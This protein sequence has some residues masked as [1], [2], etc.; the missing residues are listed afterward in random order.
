MKDI[1]GTRM[2]TYEKM[3][4]GKLMPLLPIVARLDGRSFSTF[5]KGL[6][7]PYDNRMVA[8]MQKTTK[9]LVEQ[10]GAIIG[11]TQ[12]DEITLVFYSDNNETEIFFGGKAYKLVST[13]A[14]MASV[15]FNNVIGQVIPE[16]AGMLAT[17]DCRV[18]QTPNLM[19]AANA[20]LWREIDAIRNSIISSTRSYYSHN[21]VLNKNAAEMLEMLKDKDVNWDNYPIYFKRGTYYQKRK[22]VRKYTVEEVENLPPKH[23]ARFNPD[24]AVERTEV[25]RIYM[26]P[27]TSIANKVDVLFYCKEPISV[28]KKDA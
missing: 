26:P 22:T 12:S 15:F 5:T 17:F 27:L 6:N 9:Y 21:Q 4:G 3:F 11:Y 19:E 13:L 14:A 24:L 20:I 25:T 1:I 7:K 23:E 8:A 2:K 10:T 28:N 18:F 16:K